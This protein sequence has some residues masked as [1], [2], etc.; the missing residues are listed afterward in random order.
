MIKK[1]LIKNCNVRI[2]DINHA[3]LIYA[4]AALLLKGKKWRDI[5]KF[6]QDRTHTT[7]ITN[8]RTSYNVQLYIDFFFVNGYPFISTKSV[9]LK[10]VTAHPWKSRSTAQTKTLLD[11]VL[12]KYDARGSNVN[13]IHRDNDVTI[14]QLKEYPLPIM[15][16]I[17]GRYEHV[18]I[19]ERVI[20]KDVQLYTHFFFF[21]G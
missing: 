17:Y 11:M 19:I 3:D 2:D 4:P 9:K 15:M 18:D 16:E 7:A 20:N 14:A 13:I 5:K 1:Q 12:E 21:N 6:R 10:F 8:I